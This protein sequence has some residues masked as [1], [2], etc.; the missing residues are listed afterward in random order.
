MGEMQQQL[1][2]LLSA[3]GQISPSL[4]R[5]PQ[6]GDLGAHAQTVE[7]VYRRLGGQ[8]AEIPLNL[9]SWDMEF[10]GVAV[11]LD[12]YLHFNRYRA[13]TLESSA[14]EL[15]PHF[16][17]ALYRD[18]CAV[19][20]PTCLRV[21]GY[22]GK[23]SNG[24]AERQFGLSPAAKTFDGNGPARWKQRAFY[25]FVK[26][27]SPL[28]VDVRVVRIAVWDKITEDGRIR[29]VEEALSRPV[30]STAYA[31]VNLVRERAA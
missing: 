15:L 17:R 13:I 19:F 16:P 28:L 11:E 24:S 12:E 8:L 3:I 2:K 7:E 26:D 9:R 6:L 30:E 20:E 27:L 22:G 21:G 5:F 14:Y 29:T 18:Y 1:T 25:D 4:L 31:L 10:D 23:W